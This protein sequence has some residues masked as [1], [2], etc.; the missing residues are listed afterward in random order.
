MLHGVE[1]PGDI[2]KIALKIDKIKK[3][4]FKSRMNFRNTTKIINNKRV[5]IVDKLREDQ[6]IKIMIRDKT[7]R[8]WV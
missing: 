5:S 3:P 8:S 6:I 2:R 7:G 1:W 4:G